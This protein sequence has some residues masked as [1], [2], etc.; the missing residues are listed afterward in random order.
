MNTRDKFELQLNKHA[1]AKGLCRLIDLI[2]SLHLNEFKVNTIVLILLMLY[3]F[4]TI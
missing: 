1:M 4:V 3:D 2:E